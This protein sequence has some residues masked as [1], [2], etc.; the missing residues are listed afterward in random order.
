MFQCIGAPIVI[1]LPHFLNA[2]PSLLEKIQ[3]GLAPNA[4]EHAVYIDFERV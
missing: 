4:T 2:D 3:S 1:S